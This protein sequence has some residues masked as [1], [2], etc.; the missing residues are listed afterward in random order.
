LL[1]NTYYLLKLKW[2]CETGAATSPVV[3]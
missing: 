3:D 1:I 2:V